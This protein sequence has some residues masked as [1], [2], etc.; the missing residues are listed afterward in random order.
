MPTWQDRQLWGWAPTRTCLD[1]TPYYVLF[2]QGGIFLLEISRVNE[3]LILLLF[4]VY[5]CSASVCACIPLERLAP[6]ETR[7]SHCV[8]G[9]WSYE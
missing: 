6:P 2:R 3:N 5:E 7:R 4:Y 8:P 9:N 1:S